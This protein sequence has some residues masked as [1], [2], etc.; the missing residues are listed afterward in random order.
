MKMRNKW[1]NVFHVLHESLPLLGTGIHR[2][3]FFVFD[4]G[5]KPKDYSSVE[6]M[7]LVDIG[8]RV[9]WCF[10]EKGNGDSAYL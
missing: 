10:T 2:Y 6:P 3:N 5:V 8:R 9:N 4:E 7:D 1:K